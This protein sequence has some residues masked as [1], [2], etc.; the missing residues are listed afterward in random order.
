MQQTT[1]M[2]HFEQ[3]MQ[4]EEIVFQIPLQTTNISILQT[5]SPNQMV[6]YAPIAHAH[7]AH[8]DS[9]ICDAESAA[10]L[11]LLTPIT[12][13]NGTQITTTTTAAN[14]CHAPAS[15]VDILP[16]GTNIFYEVSANFDFFWIL[17]YDERKT[18]KTTVSYTILVRIYPRQNN[19]RHTKRYKAK[20]SI[21]SI[22][23]SNIEFLF[24]FFCTLSSYPL[25]LYRQSFFPSKLLHSP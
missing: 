14:E 2:T 6:N 13:L 23:I 8:A 21:A 17:F 15:N 9:Y 22:A 5:A 1:E 4:R 12:Q 19:I 11:I 16:H 20:Q 10:P 18:S 25:S 3:S 24:F 7:P